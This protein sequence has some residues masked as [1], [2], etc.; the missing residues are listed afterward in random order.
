MLWGNPFASE[1][2]ERDCPSR[3]DVSKR[4]EEE[5]AEAA[6]GDAGV[7]GMRVATDCNA[8]RKCF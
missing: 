4:V 6:E 3:V 5:V 2:R 8:G 7:A 1:R